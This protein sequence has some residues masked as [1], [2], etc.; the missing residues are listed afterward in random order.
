VIVPAQTPHG[1]KGAGDDTLRLVSIRPSGTAEQ[2]W[3]SS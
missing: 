3:L 1:F 2:T